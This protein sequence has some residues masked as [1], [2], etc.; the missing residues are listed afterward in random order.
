[1]LK[2]FTAPFQSNQA[3]FTWGLKLLISLMMAVASVSITQFGLRILP[4]WNGWYYIPV[5]VWFVSIEAILTKDRL[6][7]LEF[8]ARM[9]YHAAE[10]VIF[11]ILLKITLYLT[12]GI[13][14]LWIDLPRWQQ[15]PIHFF[16]GAFTPILLILLFAWTMSKSI[17]DDIELLQ[18]EMTDLKW[19]LGKLEN[20]RQDARKHLAERIFFIGGL[21][22]F[23]TMLT[24]LDLKQ[25]WGETPASQASIAFVLV[26]F[27]LALVLLSQT[28]FALLR[29]RW[30]WNQTPA[31]PDIGRNW[32][33]FS[34][35]L[36]ALITVISFL[37]PT[38]YTFG[39]LEVMGVIIY[40]IFQVVFFIIN[41][42]AIPCAWLFSLFGVKGGPTQ[43][44]NPLPL[45]N[46]NNL[47][48]TSTPLPWWELLKSILFWGIFIGVIMFAIIYFF[49][50]NSSLINFLKRFQGF[51]WLSR[52]LGSFWA[53]IR[54]VNKQFASV[55]AEGIQR[56]F[57]SKSGSISFSMQ[58]FINFR[59]LSPRQQVIFY[60]IR[61]IERSKKSG[62]NRKPYQT[63]NQF[64]NE[65]ENVIPEVKQEV[66]NLTDTFTEA[67]YTFH[68]I[69]EIHTSR[70]Q[71]LWRK[72]VQSLKP[73]EK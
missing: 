54:G 45:P 50:Q 67:R 59:H 17:A 1:M 24:R 41:L 22:V 53:W 10:W 39:F 63:P 61:L 4:G 32:I 12:T 46:L 8:R 66:Q 13:N 65:L 14:Q 34:L 38:R 16:E 44:I 7:D 2:N 25:I 26:Y 57:R 43:T 72:I 27:L 30:F 6:D 60:Y 64:A 62:L 51:N 56:V 71:K 29:G 20:S 31:S 11:A 36:F 42:L 70:A 68:P 19:E 48:T 35:I 69:D 47:Q 18:S 23:I 73:V 55:I 15:D 21:M 28:Q 9:I 58:R 49:R 40:Y 33:K 5:I 52:S 3:I 37:L